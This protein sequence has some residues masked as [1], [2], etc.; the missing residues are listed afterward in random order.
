MFW[1]REIV[2]KAWERVEWDGGPSGIRPLLVSHKR[3]E[4][5]S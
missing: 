2:R 3:A 5:A 1:I 4:G